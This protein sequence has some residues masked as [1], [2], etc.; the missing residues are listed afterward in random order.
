MNFLSIGAGWGS[1][2]LDIQA[3]DMG[4][5]LRPWTSIVVVDGDGWGSPTL[6]TQSH[7]MGGGRALKHP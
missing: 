1:A 6:D 7:Y 4:G 3:E 5:G 2:A